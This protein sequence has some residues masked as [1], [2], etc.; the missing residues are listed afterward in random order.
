MRDSKIDFYKGMLM[1]GVI[2]GHTIN[3][4]HLSDYTCWIHLFFRTYDMPFFMLLSGV[5]LA[6]SIQKYDLK[7][8]LLNKLTT[9]FVPLAVWR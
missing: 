6:V 8:L 4:Y 3:A 5:F 7:K 9:L 2:W 1:V